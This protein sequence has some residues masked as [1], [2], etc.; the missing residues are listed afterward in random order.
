MHAR[1]PYHG[2]Y[3]LSAQTA[4]NLDA[5]VVP[6]AAVLNWYRLPVTQWNRDEL[7]DGLARSLNFPDH[8][9]RN[10]DAAWDCLTEL[11]W[12]ADEHKVIVLPC[13]AQPLYDAHAMITFINLMEEACEHWKD[14]GQQLLVLI[15]WDDSCPA[16]EWLSGV[17]ILANE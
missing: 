7:L 4:E 6:Q 16:P 9:G 17:P 10:W 13:A 8:F 14:Q 1:L 12:Q 15:A 5:T 11:T 2:V 3:R